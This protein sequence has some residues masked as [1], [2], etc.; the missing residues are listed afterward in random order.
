MNVFKGY[1]VNVYNGEF[2]HIFEWWIAF[3]SGAAYVIDT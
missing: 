1:F 2:E 3:L